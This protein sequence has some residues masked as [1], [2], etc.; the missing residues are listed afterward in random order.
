MTTGFD[1]VVGSLFGEDEGDNRL[2]NSSGKKEDKFR[3]TPGDRRT[4]LAFVSPKSN[5]S[6]IVAAEGES[7]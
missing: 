4:S 6:F 3:G 5:F 7:W 1:S 2:S